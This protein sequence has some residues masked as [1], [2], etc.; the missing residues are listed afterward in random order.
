MISVNNINSDN[1]FLS[2]INSLIKVNDS[3]ITEKK[4]NVKDLY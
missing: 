1:K 4:F 2:Q 3:T